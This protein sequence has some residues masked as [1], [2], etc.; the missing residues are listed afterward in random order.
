MNEFYWLPLLNY[1]K[2][3]HGPVRAYDGR[4]VSYVRKRGDIPGIKGETPPTQGVP[5]WDPHYDDIQHW[6]AQTV[7]FDV[8]G[9]QVTQQAFEAEL[10]R[11]TRLY[12]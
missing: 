8:K 3:Y 2:N 11:A 4:I 9:R 6:R 12:G 5:P 1:S 7:Y 10:A